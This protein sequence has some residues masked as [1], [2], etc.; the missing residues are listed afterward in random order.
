MGAEG[1]PR[2]QF[3]RPPQFLF[4][5]KRDGHEVVKGLF[6]RHKLNQKIYIALRVGLASLK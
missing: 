5:Q 2:H 1:L 6:S 3:Y 4:Q